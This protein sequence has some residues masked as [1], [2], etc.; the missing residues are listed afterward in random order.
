LSCLEFDLLLAA[1]DDAECTAAPAATFGND[2]GQHLIA[3]AGCNSV[4]AGDSRRERSSFDGP[5][6]RRPP[7]DTAAVV[8]TCLSSALRPVF[9][10]NPPPPVAITVT[11]IV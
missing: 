9:V 1:I 11:T 8:R 4:V 10:E 6:Q 5:M 7:S 2:F 3:R